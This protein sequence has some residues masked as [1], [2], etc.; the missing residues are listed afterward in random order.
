MSPDS[1]AKKIFSG[2]PP[3]HDDCNAFLRD[4]P[5]PRRSFI[6]EPSG[7]QRPFAE[8]IALLTRC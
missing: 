1:Y 2:D 3:S 4:V 8:P 6:R 7:M 5:S